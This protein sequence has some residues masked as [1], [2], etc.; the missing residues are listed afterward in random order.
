MS[1]ARAICMAIWRSLIWFCIWICLSIYILKLYIWLN[2]C[3]LFI[4]WLNKMFV[5]CKKLEAQC[6]LSFCFP[7]QAI[8]VSEWPIFR[9]LLLWNHLAKLTET[10]QETFMECPLWRLLISSRLVNKHGHH[11]Q[12]LFTTNDGCQVMPKAHMAF[13][14]VS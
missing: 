2:I 5:S 11:R 7:P 12:F 10:W 6:H 14:T 1:L 3:F 13:S 8:L 9:N 4:V